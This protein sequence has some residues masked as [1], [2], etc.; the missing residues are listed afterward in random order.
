MT[1]TP[2][3]RLDGVS[4]SFDRFKAVDGVS[5]VIEPGTIYG[6]LGPNGAGK[7]TTIRMIMR[8][9]YPDSGAIEVLGSPLSSIEKDRIG[10][11]PEER[12]L[13]RKMKVLDLLAFFGQVKSMKRR[14]ARKSAGEWLERL[15]LSNVAHK[16]V[17]EL[18]KGMQQKVQFISTILHDPD[19]LILDEP[20][21][22]LDPV[23]TNILKD[24][25]LEF[26]RKGHTI[27]FSTH[28]M[29]QVEK[30]CSEICLID[31]GRAILQGKLAD[32]KKEYGHNTISMRFNGDGS[33]LS[34]L[35]DVE[36][37]N[38]HGNG[39][40][41]RLRE[42]ARTRNILAAAS[43][44]LDIQKFEVAEPSIHDI[45]VEQVGGGAT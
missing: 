1:A 24:I 26:N 35:P 31:D 45:F 40:F 33:F 29:D 38:D 27:I 3:V 41:I 39:V 28:M 2:A 18:S 6:L 32:I 42:G 23:N 12:G 36:S 25:I 43:E 37:V 17:E 5:L 4:K 44:R 34:E 21:S 8:I 13:Y 30:L 10:Y 15:R 14:V 16:K 22:G 20:F 9:M 7:T 11:L 19:L